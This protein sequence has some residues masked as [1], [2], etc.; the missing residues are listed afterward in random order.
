[1]EIRGAGGGSLVWG[2]FFLLVDFPFEQGGKAYTS[3][4]D[5]GRADDTRMSMDS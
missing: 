5:C 2:I 1:M 3:L 4:F